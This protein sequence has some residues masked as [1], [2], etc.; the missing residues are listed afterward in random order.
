MKVLA[1]RPRRQTTHTGTGTSTKTKANTPIGTVGT[2][3][4]PVDIESYL[5]RFNTN[6]EVRTQVV[7]NFLD[8]FS[9]SPLIRDGKVGGVLHIGHT[10]PIFIGQSP[11]LDKAV[12]ALSSAFLAKRSRDLH[13][14]QYS[15]RLYGEALQIVHGRIRSGRRCGQDSLFATVFFQFYELINS[16]PLGFKAWTSHVKGSNAILGQYS[17]SSPP[18]VTDHLFWRQLKFVTVCDAIGLRKSIYSYSSFWKRPALH[19]PWR[20]SVDVILDSIIECSAL[21]EAVDF[22]IQHG[23][24]DLQDDIQTG[25]KLLHGCLQLKDH[26]DTSFCEMQARLGVPYSSP[27]QQPFWSTIDTSIPREVFPDAI[28][29]PCLTCAESHLLWWT[30]YILLYPLIDQ[31]LTFLGRSRSE[32]S[33][34]MWD[35]PSSSTAGTSSHSYDTWAS[36][37]PEDFLGVADHYAGLICRSAKFLVQPETKAMGTQILLA[38]FSQA[39]QFYH[40]REAIE[41]YRW[42]QSVF[43][44]FSRLGFGIAPFLKDM[45]WPKYEAATK[46]KLPTS[47]SR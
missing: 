25:E 3:S 22:L 2:A 6:A 20:E 27:N 12:T 30:T 36:E 13:L 29:Y 28:E 47:S 42:C 38:P 26:L 39:T 14:L 19:N 18:T 10:F 4:G 5:H 16:S 31:L 11:V 44:V 15:A 7:A 40:S 17:D 35:I 33:F 23:H 46:K 43:M 45:I 41:K 32:I 24:Q 9:P 21:I 1:R 37:L 8:S 34:N